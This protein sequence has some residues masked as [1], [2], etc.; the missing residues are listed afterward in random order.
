MAHR[1]LGRGMI[2]ILVSQGAGA[3]A[4]GSLGPTGC[5]TDMDLY[6]YLCRCGTREPRDH[7]PARSAPLLSGCLLF[8][9]ASCLNKFIYLSIDQ[10]R[11]PP[12]RISP[13]VRTLRAIVVR[14][15]VLHMPHAIRSTHCVERACGCA[16]QNVRLKRPR[17]RPFP[18]RV[19]L[20][21][22]MRTGPSR[23]SKS[24][25][26]YGHP[27]GS[28]V[29]QR[30]ALHPSTPRCESIWRRRS[31]TANSTLTRRTC[32]ECPPRGCPCIVCLVAS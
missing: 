17:S 27:A 20:R 18:V 6:L 19:G 16:P 2:R 22:R 21:G 28:R 14:S 26:P 24:A 31:A 5:G 29:S 1:A 23:T 30:D 4:L 25:A 7:V 12:R 9:R 3:L 15:P 13:H 10:L 11:D 8:A 32:A